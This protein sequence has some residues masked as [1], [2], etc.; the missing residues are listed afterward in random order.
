MFEVNEGQV[1]GILNRLSISY[2]RHEHSPVFTIEESNQLNIIINATRCK[3]LFLRNK[4][5]NQYYLVVME[6]SKTANLK[7]LALQIGS[8]AL[9]FASEER[10]VNILGLTPGSVSPF[11]LINDNN[12]KIVVLMDQQLVFSSKLSF[13][14]NINTTTIE[15]LSEDFAKYLSWCG[16]K[17][18]YVNI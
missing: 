1:L 4:K 12:K 6:H 2:T 18:L 5:G 9:S 16:N 15:I 3:N 7:N 14:P 13:H 17:L 8:T 10:M 11:G